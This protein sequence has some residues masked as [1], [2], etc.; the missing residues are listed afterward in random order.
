MN[1]PLINM[2]VPPYEKYKTRKPIFSEWLETGNRLINEGKPEVVIANAYEAATHM[3]RVG[4]DN[5]LEIHISNTLDSSA[6]YKLWRQAM[7]SKT[8]D[9][10]SRYQKLYPNCDFAQVSAEIKRIGQVLSE[11]QYLFHGG[12]WPGGQRLITNRPL[13]TSFCP[14]VA[15]RNAE[16]KGK[17]Y[18]S[19]RIDLFV[20]RA[21]NPKTNVFAYKRKG[22]N[23]GHEQEVLFASGANLTLESINVVNSNHLVGK[24]NYPDKRIQV[25]VLLLNIS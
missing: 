17:A 8:P 12:L 6:A 15:L 14:Q 4:I 10:L 21:A 25:R 18:D 3:G 24:Y 20:L 2:F 1:L 23:L 22:T 16:H 5:G 13:S 19:G 7:P 9:V 11:G